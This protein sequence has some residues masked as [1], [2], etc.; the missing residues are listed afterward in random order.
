MVI[1]GAALI[2]GAKSQHLTSLDIGG[3]EVHV[4]QSGCAD[5]RV[6]DDPTAIELIRRDIR[7]LP[8][9]AIDFYRHGCAPAAPNYCPTEIAEL[10]PPDYRHVYSIEEVIARLVDQSLFHEVLAGVGREIIAG[11]ARISGLWVGIIANR[12]GIIDEPGVGRRLGGAL[13]REGIAKI[14]SFS[15]TCSDDGVPLIWLQDI[16]GFDIGEEAEALGLLGYGSNLIYANSTPKHPVFTVLLRKASGAGYYAMAG[17]PYEPIVQLSSSISRLAVMEGRTLAIATYGPHLND[18]FEVATENPRERA[19]IE[20]GMAKVESRIQADM[21]PVRAAA[22]MDTDEVVAFDELRGWLECLVESAWQSAGYRRTKNPRIWSVHDLGQIVPPS[23]RGTVEALL[24]EGALLSP[25][26]GHWSPAHSRA[27]ETKPGERIGQLVQGD[28]VLD[29]L[30]PEGAVGLIRPTVGDQRWV[31]CGDEIAKPL[32]GPLSQST[33]EVQAN[34][35]SAI[36]PDVT[37]V[38]ADTEGTVHL[39][40]EPGAPPFVVVG[41]Q[42]Q[43]KTTLA[44]IEVMKTFTPVRAGSPGCVVRLLAGDGEAVSAGQS[45]MWVRK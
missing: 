16:S 42:V 38:L 13:Y 9:S 22:S 10:F 28:G 36:P 20:A 5:T 34:P 45:L 8:S 19:E 25:S 37:E 4:H 6:P 33:Q 14:T 27:F 32:D 30:C 12:Q 7:D 17:M 18:D 15:R 29:V 44:L 39:S 23:V 21:D 26:P 40:P 31:E 3:P 35:S 24:S 11:M 43:E 1:A 2:K 41:D